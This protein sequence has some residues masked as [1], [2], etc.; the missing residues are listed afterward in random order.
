MPAGPKM[1]VGSDNQQIHV[2]AGVVRDR[3]GKILLTRR[4]QHVHKGGCWEF[5]GGKVRTGESEL[6]A[7][8]RELAEEV[9]I[10]VRRTRP[11][12]AIHHTY[13]DRDIR[14]AVWHVQDYGGTAVGRENQQWTWSRQEQLRSYHMPEANEAVVNALLLPD[15]YLVTPEPGDQTGRFVDSIDRCLRNGTRLIQLRAKTVQ[16][17]NYRAIARIVIPLCHAYKAQVLLNA[18]A[19][20]V[21]ELAADGV[22]LTS[23]A[24]ANTAHRPLPKNR[25]VAASCHNQKELEQARRIGCDFVVLSPVHE[26]NSHPGSKALGWTRFA[27]LTGAANMPV[28]GLGGLGPADL[29]A[30]YQNGAQGVAA[31]RGLWEAAGN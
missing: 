1:S 19:E 14:L 17:S 8:R 4:P 30:A 12:I 21:T 6:E 26:T 3:H 9:G 31:M 16:P 25:W 27:Q 7:L 11:L 18:P 20:W 28:Y 15:F 2:V 10:Q 23:R 24:L 29:S 13:P 22:H 5:P